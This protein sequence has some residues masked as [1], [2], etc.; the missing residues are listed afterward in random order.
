M[1]RSESFLISS[2]AS[3]NKLFM[4]GHMALASGKPIWSKACRRGLNLINV[5]AVKDRPTE[6]VLARIDQEEYLFRWII[7][8]SH[9]LC[10]QAVSCQ[11]VTGTLSLAIE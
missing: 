4:T 6:G 1:Q 9:I 10:L 11:R 2:E 8:E 7:E 3:G 5:L